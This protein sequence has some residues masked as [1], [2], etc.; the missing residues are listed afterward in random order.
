MNI[1]NRKKAEE[2]ILTYIDKILPDGVNKQLYLD[3]FKSMSDKDFNTWMEKLL[4]GETV[5]S[6]IAPNGQKVKLDVKRNL[7]IAKEIGHE[8][9]QRYWS[10]T[11]DGRGWYRSNDKYLIIDVPIRRQAQLLVKKISFAK[12]NTSVDD[13]TGQPTGASKSAKISFP[14]VQMLIAK[15]LDATLCEFMKF[16]GGDTKGFAAMEASISRT[17]G[18]SLKALTPYTS[19]V[20]STMTL[21]SMLT[22]MHLS[23]NLPF[24]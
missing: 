18:A 1:T 5:L 9:F 24:Y 2:Y 17:G 16:R 22:S 13:L 19:G 7:D 3:K 14:E 23:N 12:N 8:F 4:S 6:L 10:R 21:Y 15:G 11:P 20:K